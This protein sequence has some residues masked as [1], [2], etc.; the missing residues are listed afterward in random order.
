VSATCCVPITEPGGKPV[1]EVPGLN[2]KSPVIVVAPVLVIVVLAKTA[3]LSALKR[4]TA[5]AALAA[6][7][8]LKPTPKERTS[9]VTKFFHVLYFYCILFINLMI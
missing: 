5:V 8:P 1:T 9:M 3:K 2:P 4:F 6:L 7:G